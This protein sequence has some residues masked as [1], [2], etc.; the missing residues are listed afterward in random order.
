[1]LRIEGYEDWRCRDALFA[2][3]GFSKTVR[4]GPPEN[5]A[6]ESL[7][8]KSHNPKARL[9]YTPIRTPERLIL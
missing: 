8:L 2:D 5:P 9:P 6:F 4:L 3:V 7:H 1:M